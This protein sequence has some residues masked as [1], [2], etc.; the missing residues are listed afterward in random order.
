MWRLPPQ[1]RK[2]WILDVVMSWFSRQ[3]CTKNPQNFGR[4]PPT[5]PRKP[6][7]V[8]SRS[9]ERGGV[10]ESELPWSTLIIHKPSAV[11]RGDWQGKRYIWCQ[12]GNGINVGWCCAP[13]KLEPVYSTIPF[14]PPAGDSWVRLWVIDKRDSV[15][16]PWEAIQPIEVWR[17]RCTTG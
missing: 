6:P 9:G 1:A 14:N 2:L 10:F 13:R 16:R 5:N 8:N 15:L 17:I 7:L 12:I 11:R 3:F 4:K